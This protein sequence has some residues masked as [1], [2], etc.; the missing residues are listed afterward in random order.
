LSFVRPF[1]QAIFVILG[2]S[3]FDQF[4]INLAFNLNPR[5]RN[6]SACASRL[7]RPE[8]SFFIAWR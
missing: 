1:S 4:R 6:A 7:P 2:G 8:A 5:L 3:L